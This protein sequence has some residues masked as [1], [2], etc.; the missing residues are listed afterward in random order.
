MIKRLLLPED[1]DEHM[2]PSGKNQPTAGEIALVK[3]WINVGAPTDKTIE[4]LR[5]PEAE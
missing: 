3:W 5:M 1:S 4:D 2:P